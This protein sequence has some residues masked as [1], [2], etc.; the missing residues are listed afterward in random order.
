V[1]VAVL[2]VTEAQTLIAQAA[3]A[4]QALFFSNTQYLYLP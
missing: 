2:A 4:D 3:P 1:V